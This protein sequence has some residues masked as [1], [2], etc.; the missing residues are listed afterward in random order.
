MLHVQFRDRRLDP[1]HKVLT[2]RL[3]T[4]QGSIMGKTRELNGA[5]APAS[6][7]VDDNREDHQ[8]LQRAP[9]QTYS[10]LDRQ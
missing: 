10:R 3:V 9:T 2:T 1:R 5:V 6:I 4:S 7:F 8:P